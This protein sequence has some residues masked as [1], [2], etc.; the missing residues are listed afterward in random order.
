MF[1]RQLALPDHHVDFAQSHGEHAKGSDLVEMMI[2]VDLN[3]FDGVEGDG[4]HVL[5]SVLALSALLLD[6]DSN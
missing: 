3:L 6:A 1:E 4:D 2:R 5:L